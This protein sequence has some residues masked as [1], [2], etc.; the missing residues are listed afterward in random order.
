MSQSSSYVTDYLIQLVQLQVDEHHV[1]VWFDPEKHYENLADAKNFPNSHLYAYDPNMGFMALRRQLEEVWRGSE[2]PRLLIYAPIAQE[3]SQH[4]LLEYIRAGVTLQ[5]GEQPLERNTRLALIAQNALKCV[6]P[7]ANLSKIIADVEKGQLRLPDLDDIAA[8]Y[9]DIEVGVLALIFKSENIED[10][11]LQFL[12]TDSYDPDILERNAVKNLKTLFES[13]FEIKFDEK[14]SLSK[15]REKLA[16]HLLMIDFIGHLKSKPESLSTFVT[17]KSKNTMEMIMRLVEDWRQRNDYKKSYIDAAEIVEQQVPLSQHN[18]TIDAL[19]NLE[20]FLGLEAVYQSLIENALLKEAK[21]GLVEIA[22]TRQQSFW[23]QQRP[24]LAVR[25]KMIARAGQ[26]LVQSLKIESSLAG[27]NQTANQMIHNYSGSSS[28][29]DPEKAPWCM[30][31]TT[32]RKLE[33][34]ENRFDFEADQHDTLKKLLA[35]ARS[36]YVDVVHNMTESFMKSFKRTNYHLPDINQQTR[37]FHDFIHPADEKEKIAFILVD[38]FRYEMGLEFT[39]MCRDEWELQISP[40][41]ATIPSITEVGMSALLPGAEQGIN[42]VSAGGGKLAVRI[43]DTNLKNRSDRVKYLE[44]KYPN[45]MVINLNQIVPLKEKRVLQGLKDAKLTVVTASDEIDGLW[46]TQPDIARRIHDA[47]FN[48]L[49]RG[50]KSLINSG[51]NKIFITSDHGFLAGEDIMVGLPMDTPGGETVDLH[52]RVWVGRGGKELPACIREPLTSFGTESELEVVIPKGLGCFKVPGGSMQYYHGGMSL[53][54]MIIPVIEIHTEKRIP[55]FV[56][57]TP[58]NWKLEIGSKQIT[59]RFFTVT[60]SGS[61]TELIATPPKIRLELRSGDQ[62]QSTIMAATYGFNDT[63]KDISMKMESGSTLLVPNTI[64]LLIEDLSGE[65]SS[66]DLYM[67]NS[68]NGVVL[69]KVPN[70]D[71]AI[72]F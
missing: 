44:T 53:Q 38:A 21:P 25:W 48:Q 41:L 23:P 71:V 30:L 7:S 6:L 43:N 42:I 9:K 54:E 8:K 39:E 60:I 17:P 4:G 16:K 15:V 34:E 63:A 12:A 69:T 26:V 57:E 58:F 28:Q 33:G 50:I 70:I 35:A 27:N 67:I 46:E 19:E 36:R 18:W 2:P 37:I 24:E 40:S 62:V 66:L 45:S 31:D 68:E 10:I 49:R 14:A 11:C 47:V 1:V 3:D 5:P 52:R 61:A 20:T 56:R 51:Y 22:Q 59:T 72:V 32:F 55:S 13:A 29:M 65:I 64:T